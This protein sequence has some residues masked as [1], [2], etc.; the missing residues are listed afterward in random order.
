M[1][2]LRQDARGWTA[3]HAV[4]A[5]GHL[6]AVGL[7]L[8]HGANVNARDFKYLHVQLLRR[9]FSVLTCQRTRH[10]TH[11]AHRSVTPL[12]AAARGVRT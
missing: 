1:L 8:S 12:I 11:T 6:E 2:C 5:S 3:L 9:P 4:C 10:T 7:L